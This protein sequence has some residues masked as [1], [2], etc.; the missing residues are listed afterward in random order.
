MSLPLAELLPRSDTRLKRWQRRC[1]LGISNLPRTSSTVRRLAA[2]LMVEPRGSTG[3]GSWRGR[4]RS[5]SRR[6]WRKSSRYHL[7][8]SSVAC[9]VRGR[10]VPTVAN[11]GKH[12]QN[13]STPDWCVPA[14]RT[15]PGIVD[16]MDQKDSEACDEALAS[17][18]V[19]DGAGVWKACVAGSDAQCAFPPSISSVPK[20]PGISDSMDQKASDASDET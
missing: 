3:G 17:P 4:S 11:R 13:P 2:A 16:D 5:H 1:Q 18:G 10:R 19:E 9:R 8:S 6:P 7:G 20:R 14:G 12:Q 15:M